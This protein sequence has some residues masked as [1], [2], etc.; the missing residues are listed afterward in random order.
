MD[1]IA[2]RV[3]KRVVCSVLAGLFFGSLPAWQ[4]TEVIFISW[5]VNSV[6]FKRRLPSTRFNTVRYGIKPFGSTYESI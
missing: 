3:V 5:F 4:L 2:E 1:P 6:E